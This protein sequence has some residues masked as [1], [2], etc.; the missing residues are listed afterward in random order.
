VWGYYSIGKN[1]LTDNLVLVWGIFTYTTPQI[2]LGNTMKTYWANFFH[3]GNPTVSGDGLPT[4]SGITAS[5]KNTMVFQS[6]NSGTGASLNP[7]VLLT[8]CYAEPTADFRRSQAN[9]FFSGFSAT[10]AAPATCS[11]PTV[12]NTT[13]LSATCNLGAGCASWCNS[14]TCGMTSCAGCSSTLCPSGPLCRSWC[15]P[16]TCGLTSCAGCAVCATPYCASW[17]NSYT[18]SNTYCAGC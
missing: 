1:Y 5:S 13:A 7:C 11:N 10:A 9:F 4:W 17:C 18:S 16:Y 14:Y 15:N 2:T 12:F 6:S 3:T 8:S